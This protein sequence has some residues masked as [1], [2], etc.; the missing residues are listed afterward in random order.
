MEWN[1]TFGFLKAVQY[2]LEIIFNTLHNYKFV[3][4]VLGE[5][6]PVAGSL[7]HPLET[8]AEY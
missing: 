5:I 7:V 4:V 2:R 6:I 8:A 3:P 1:L